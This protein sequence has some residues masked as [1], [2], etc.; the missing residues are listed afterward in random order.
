M[1]LL[2]RFLPF[3][4]AVNYSFIAPS[5]HQASGSIRRSSV[6]PLVPTKP[7]AK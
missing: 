5:V 1:T 3:P 2:D 4:A 7:A 6:D